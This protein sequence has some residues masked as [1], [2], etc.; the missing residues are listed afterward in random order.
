M[1]RLDSTQYAK[2][3]GVA[4]SGVSWEKMS[5]KVVALSG[6]TGM[7]GTFLVDLIMRQNDIDGLG[8]GIVA[9]GRSEAKA[10]K[11]LPYFGRSDF[12]FVECDVSALGFEPPSSVDCILHLASSTH[13]RQ[14]ASDP[15]G[16][17]DANVVG[18]RN[19]LEWAASSSARMLFASSVEVYGENRGDVE[20]FDEGYCGYVDCNTLRA[21]YTES[22]RL[23]E[24][25]C[26]AY[27][28]QRGVEAVI[29]RIARVYGPTLLPDDSK[30]LSQFLHRALNGDDVILK[31][32]GMQRYSY[33]YS[34]DA[35]AGILKVLLE[36]ADGEAYNLADPASDISLS[37]LARLV[38]RKGEV[39][40][41]FELPSDAETAGY[42]K[43][44]LALMDPSKAN[45]LGW[46]ARWSI[47]E[48]VARTLEML[49]MGCKRF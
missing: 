14:Y 23:G 22:K 40:V 7:I 41:S 10:R 38:A 39:A 4:S 34:A 28:V 5:G 44:T 8:C 21:C 35:A 25:M 13:P 37:D 48:G 46:K 16:T 36:G 1:G 15:V 49:G 9:L 20:R 45:A 17:I 12:S 19:M 42:S 18:L 26:Q 33:L 30:A 47:E 27:R 2:D 24:A 29:A 3:L 32:D 31:S 6:A 11:R 43:A